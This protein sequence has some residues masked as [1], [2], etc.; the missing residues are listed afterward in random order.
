MKMLV[1]EK[2]TSTPI[3]SK[4]RTLLDAVPA[5]VYAVDKELNYTYVN[6]A[7]C[8]FYN[9]EP[10]VA[11]TTTLPELAG[12]EVYTTLEK[13]ILKALHGEVVRFE[14]VIPFAKADNFFEATFTPEIDE[15]GNVTGYMAFAQETS[16]KRKALSDQK[17]ADI[18]KSEERYHKMINEVQDYAIILL[19]KDGNIQNWN[20]G[21][22]NIKGYTAQEA[23]GMHFSVFYLPQDREKKL[24]QQLL[25]TARKKGRA[26]HEG[27]RVKKDGTTFWGSIV[28]TALH[29][30]QGNVIGFSKVTRDLTERKIAEDKREHLTEELKQK[31]E[32]LRKSEERYHKMI[33]EVLDY[34]IIL[35]DKEGN[36]L[37][38][39]KGAQKIK[40]YKAEEAIGMNFRKFYLPQDQQNKLPEKLI[41]EAEKNG[42]ATHEGLRV[43]KDGSVFWGYIVITALHDD[44]NN[45]IGFSK[46]TRDL[47]ERKIAEDKQVRLTEELKLKNESLRI[48]EERYHRMI[49]EVEDYAILLLDKEGNV[50]NWNKGAEKIK[51]YKSQEIIGKNFSIFYTKQDKEK[52]LDQ[53]LLSEAREKEK[54]I[55]EGWRVRKDG[56]QFW[57]S[58][59]ITALHD[60]NNNIIGF[61]KVTRDLTD[62]KL[63]DD[64]L[65]DY[66]SQLENQ[67]KELDHFA[68]AASHDLQEPL[69]KIITFNSLIQEYEGEKLSEKAKDYFNRSISAAERMNKLIEDL[70]TYSRAT[71]DRDEVEKVDLNT[72]I[73]RIKTSYKEVEGKVKIDSEKLPTL[74]G[75]RFQFEQLF[76][77]L[78]NN[79]VKY[80]P[81]GSTPHIKLTCDVVFGDEIKEMLVEPDKK[82]Y[83]ISVIDN[84][85]GF[86][87][88]YAEKIFEMFQRLHGKS[89]Y[90]G[91]GI[92][93]A[94]VKRIVQHYNGFITAESKPGEGATFK[95]YFPTE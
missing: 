48:S 91:T 33:E 7:F 19:D 79:A 25:E 89:E 30:E 29:D 55:H 77:N 58:I 53:K 66:A 88:E 94:I 5:L 47:T 49:D 84:G 40:G 26:S 9:I 22:Q 69:R 70:L 11:L 65:K 10:A 39:N 6:K 12:K 45:I 62:K 1:K 41:A 64:K 32:Q 59:V 21:A 37:N 87:Q 44:K 35:L 13:Y 80:Q 54:A 38:W 90:S 34:A 61:S 78:I 2:D 3:E 24:P 36:V 75:L 72:I 23:I 8:K 81:A 60:D 50:L 92:G 56:T 68:Y 15:K 57:G 73:D 16:I 74:E 52:G 27:L 31:N 42:R 43:K 28:I 76:E 17:E 67:N 20:K 95:M 14:T 18:Q 86:N 83:K 46:V 82:F 4:Y 51:G 93:L 85:I 63:A 71:R